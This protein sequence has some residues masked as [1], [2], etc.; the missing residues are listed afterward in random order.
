MVSPH[1]GNVVALDSAGHIL[2]MEIFLEKRQDRLVG[3]VGFQVGPVKIFRVPPGHFQ[4]ARPFPAPGQ[5]D[6]HGSA[7]FFP[8]PLLHGPA[9]LDVH[10]NEDFPGKG[11]FPVVVL[12]HHGGKDFPGI[13]PAFERGEGHLTLDAAPAGEQ[14]GH[15]DPVAGA[16]KPENVPVL[17]G[18][19]KNFL[20]LQ[21][22]LEGGDAVPEAGGVFKAHFP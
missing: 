21:G 6:A 15:L 13:G 19:G 18:E 5:P 16:V 4:E 9:V 2:Q 11:D 12:F 10:G 14:D 17:P 20:L 22:R 1:I 7:L 3:Q 8:E